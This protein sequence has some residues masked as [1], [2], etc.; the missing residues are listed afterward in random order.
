MLGEQVVDL[1]APQPVRRPDREELIWVL[2]ARL[3]EQTTRQLV[4]GHTLAL[5]SL[6]KSL[7]GPIVELDGEG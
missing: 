4:R 3:G 1:A 7:G 6:A 2:F 5:S